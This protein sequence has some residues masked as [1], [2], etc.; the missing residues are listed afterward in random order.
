MEK[1]FL[2]L[3]VSNTKTRKTFRKTALLRF[4]CLERTMDIFAQDGDPKSQKQFHGTVCNV[5]NTLKAS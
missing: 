1:M 5:L 3:G 4:C 2:A